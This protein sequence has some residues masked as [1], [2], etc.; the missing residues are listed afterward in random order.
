MQYRWLLVVLAGCATAGSEANEQAAVDAAVTRVDAP[1]S[2]PI[3]V[4]APPPPPC[5]ATAMKQLLV[6]P[7]FDATPAG[8]G[9][10]QTPVDPAFPIITSDDGLAEKSPAMKAWMGGYAQ[11]NANDQLFQ[12]VTIPAN[13][14]KLRLT[15]FYSVVTTEA[16]GAA[17]KDTASIELTQV[18]GTSID[19]L[20]AVNNTMTTATWT[21]IDYTVANVTGLSGTTVRFSLQTSNDA[22]AHTNFYF[23]SLVLTATH[24]P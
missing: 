7:A 1:M 18:G 23:D 2:P 12:D 4:D 20:L 11:A 16:A 5:M 8:T 17:V 13:T 14:A 22:S 19:K 9:W 24:C 6:N 21:A 15:G 10:T 3:P